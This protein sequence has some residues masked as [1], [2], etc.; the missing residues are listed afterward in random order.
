MHLGSM[1]K[2]HKKYIK[3]ENYSISN[4]YKMTYTW[5]G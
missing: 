2:L 3:Q 5:N 1:E 4:L